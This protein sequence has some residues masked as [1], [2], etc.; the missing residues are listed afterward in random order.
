MAHRVAPNIVPSND[1][2]RV[3][4]IPEIIS[5]SVGNEPMSMSEVSNHL[6]VPVSCSSSDRPFYRHRRQSTIHFPSPPKISGGYAGATRIPT[7]PAGASRRLPI[8]ISQ[9]SHCLPHKVRVA[10]QCRPGFGAHVTRKK[11]RLPKTLEEFFALKQCRYTCSR[12][13]GGS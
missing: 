13:S 4:G 9:R 10:L 5:P 11:S 12:N 1:S 2:S 6:S 3:L 7:P 8:I